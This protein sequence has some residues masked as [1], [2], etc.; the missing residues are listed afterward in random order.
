MHTL[1]TLPPGNADDMHTD[2]AQRCA[3]LGCK[4]LCAKAEIGQMLTA[5]REGQRAAL[6]PHVPLKSTAVALGQAQE[7][8]LG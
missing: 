6:T 8:F 7:V 5:Q 4:A 1:R 2:H 3:S